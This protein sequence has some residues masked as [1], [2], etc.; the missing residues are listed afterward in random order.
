MCRIAFI[1]YPETG[2]LIPTFKLA[3]GL[4]SRGHEVFYFGIPDFEHGVRSEGFGFMPVLEDLYPKGFLSEQAVKR[5]LLALKALIIE[6]RNVAAVRPGRNPLVE[7]SETL[8]R[9]RP[10]VL[11]IDNLL[12]DIALIALAADIPTILVNTQLVNPWEKDEAYKALLDVPELVLC[13]VEFD[14]PREQRR[15][16]CLNVEACIDLDRREPDFP[17]DK[18]DQ[19]KPLI[20]SALGSVSHAFEQTRTLLRSIIDA[21]ALRPEWQLILSLGHIDPT[22]FGSLPSNILTVSKAPQ[23]QILKRASLMISHGGFNSVKECIFFGVPMVLFPTFG[24]TPA[25][26]ARV[27]YHGLGIRGN[28]RVVTNHQVGTLIDTVTRESSFKTR[29]ELMRE[30]FIEAENSQ[31]GIQAVESVL[32]KVRGRLNSYSSS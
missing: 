15:K 31:L 17:W 18:I 2:H 24:D 5:G 10:E 26:T 19:S 28:A 9:A 23:L 7:L 13:P 22:T 27:L 29:V 1:T 3:K 32:T 6:A 14:F 30:K 21:V 8:K 20:Y 16:D 12:P 11:L 4:K 25:V